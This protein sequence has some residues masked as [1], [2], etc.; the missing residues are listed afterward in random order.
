MRVIK[1]ADRNALISIPIVILIGVGVAFAGSQGGVLAFRFPL[2][3]L[4]VGLAFLIQ[5]L[6]FIPA[7]LLQTEKFYDL[8]GSFTYISVTIIALLFSSIRDTRSIL[9]FVLAL[10]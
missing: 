10:W 8:I 2:F 9:L 7:F 5:W 6:T 4:L 3:A 1:K